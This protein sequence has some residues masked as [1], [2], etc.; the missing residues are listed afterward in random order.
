[1]LNKYLIGVDVGGTFTDLVVADESGKLLCLAKAS[2][3]PQ[4]PEQGVLRALERAASK[5]GLSVD[6]L[7]ENCTRFVHGTTVAT[8]ALLTRR[9]AKVGLLTTRGSEIRSRSAEAS[10]IMYGITGRP[11]PPFWLTEICA[12]PWEGG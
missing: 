1:M 7:L 3:S 9:G 5:I 10:A 12:S 2:T 6:S 8:N 11:V 4:S